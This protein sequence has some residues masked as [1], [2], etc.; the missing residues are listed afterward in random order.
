MTDP[1]VSRAL[2]EQASSIDKTI[3]LYPGMWHALTSGEPDDNVELVFSDIVAWLD[4][5]CDLDNNRTLQSQ[6]LAHRVAPVVRSAPT[7]P[8][9]NGRSKK[10][11]QS[12]AYGKYLCGWKGPRMHHHSA[13]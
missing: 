12:R 10:K 5:R 11:Q 3:K 8:L 2:Y 4:K 1:E 9:M 13:M 6:F 7:T